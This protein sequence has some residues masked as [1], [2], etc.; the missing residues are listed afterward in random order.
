MNPRAFLL[1]LVLAL[2]V[3]DV[4]AQSVADAPDCGDPPMTE[5]RIPNA[6]R[7]VREDMLA[8]VNAVKA[9][10]EAIDAWLA[11]KDRRAVT[12]FGWMNEQQ[13]ARWEEDL[14][15]IHEDRVEVQRKMNEEIR[16]FNELQAAA[17]NS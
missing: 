2:P 8:G 13:R 12:V 3:G 4:R 7:S 5:P 1:A 14:A 9:Y 17:G 10:S 6:K 15:K 11:C 16:L